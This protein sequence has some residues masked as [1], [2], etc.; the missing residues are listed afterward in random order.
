MSF[1]W[2][3]A[4][5]TIAPLLGTAIGGPIGG[6]AAKMVSA[7]LLGREDGTEEELAEA[8]QTA[9]PDQLIKLKEADNG[10]K[11]KMEEFGIKKRTLVFNDKSNARSMNTNTKAK[12]PAILAYILTLMV[13]CIVYGLMK[14]TIPPANMS[15]VNI[16]FGSVMTTWIGACQFFHGATIK[17]ENR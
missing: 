3:S 12:T 7:A 15:V 13:A 17:D 9:T 10:F 2:K 8:M 6:V 11:L 4:I 14:W 16:V 1:D 5:K